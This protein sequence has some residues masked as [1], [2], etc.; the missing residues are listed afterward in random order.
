MSATGY[1]RPQDMVRDAD[2][3]MYRA[4]SRGRAVHEVFD[5]TMHER[6]V[7]LLKFETELRRSIE[8]GE[9]RVYYQPLV[10]L[11]TNRVAGFEA[12][13]RW[14]LGDE[15]VEAGEIVPIAEDTGLIPSIGR[16]VLREACRHQKLE[17]IGLAQKRLIAMAA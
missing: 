9:L 3:A 10:S 2:I 16:W 1:E 4:K 5:K 17:R 13:V 12:L 14:Q 11:E 7:K 8:R 6:A 15:L